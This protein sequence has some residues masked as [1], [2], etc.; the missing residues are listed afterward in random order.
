[1]SGYRWLAAASAAVALISVGAVASTVSPVVYGAGELTGAGQVG[2]GI[3]SLTAIGSVISFIVS[4][5]KSGG[6]QALVTD[7]TEL[8]GPIVKGESNVAQS[9]VRVSLFILQ[10]DRAQRGDT[11]G[12]KMVQDLSARI[13]IA[14]KESERR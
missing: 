4:I 13:L 2:I 6:G 8:L 10:I 1:M 11:E 9:A 3:G 12:L 7:A 14:P 5:F